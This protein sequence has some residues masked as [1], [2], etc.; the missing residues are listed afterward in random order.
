MNMGDL[1]GDL[2][3][4]AAV[5]QRLVKLIA[6][7]ERLGAEPVRNAYERERTLVEADKVGATLEEGELKRRVREW[8]AAQRARV[9][10]A[11]E[12]FK[13]EFG[14]QF[15]AGLEG[16]G[17]TVRG[18]LP[19]LRCGLFSVRVD[20]GTGRATIFW[21]PEVERLKGGV[22]IEPL[23]LARLLREYDASLKKRAITDPADFVRRLFI[24]YR[25]LCAGQGI[26]EGE[27]VFLIDLLGEM[28]FL[29]QPEGFRVNPARERFVEYPRI[30]FSYD[31]YLLKRSGV[32][33]VEGRQLRLSVANFD[34]T[35][36]KGKALWVP[37]SE[38]G[39]GT[40]YSYI[41][42]V[43]G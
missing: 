25:R 8:V 21:G 39:D 34:A 18:Q 15:M 33:E 17:L 13:F 41:S 38:E 27:R 6:G 43:R 5:L 42:F 20:F 31:L 23:G 24:A 32:R 22:K 10:E 40:N 1:L 4:Q 19:L 11:K 29:M 35:A 9:E 7:Y 16:S 14:R 36:E 28:V 30:R 2:R 37:D 26:A 3:G 12:E